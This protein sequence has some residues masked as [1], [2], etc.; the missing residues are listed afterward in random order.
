MLKDH[1]QELR[2]K[3]AEGMH[4]GENNRTIAFERREHC[5]WQVS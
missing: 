5:E 4:L 3:R 2:F 1:G